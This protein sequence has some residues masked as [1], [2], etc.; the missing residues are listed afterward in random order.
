MSDDLAKDIAERKIFK[1]PSSHSHVFLILRMPC[2]NIT[3]FIARNME[4]REIARHFAN[5][6]HNLHFDYAK[7]E[8]LRTARLVSSFP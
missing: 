4:D 5:W 7:E 3:M 8:Q 2:Q 6:A 1:S